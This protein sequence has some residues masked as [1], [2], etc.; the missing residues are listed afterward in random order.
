M[1]KKTSTK[2]ELVAPVT[3]SN[4]TPIIE[5]ST[6]SVPVEK[7][8]RKSK[9]VTSS[10]VVETPINPVDSTVDSTVVETVVEIVVISGL[11]ENIRLELSISRMEK[12]RNKSEK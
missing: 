1:P 8:V 3:D 4:I 7:K 12:L 5:S 11:A 6:N 9:T 10:N 2:T